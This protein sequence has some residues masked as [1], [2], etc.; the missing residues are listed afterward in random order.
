MAIGADGSSPVGQLAAL[1]GGISLAILI[2]RL[3]PRSARSQRRR[4]D[5]ELATRLAR[6]VPSEPKRRIDP[7]RYPNRVIQRR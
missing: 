2:A 6:H 7:E 5:A 4:I 1:A 3:V